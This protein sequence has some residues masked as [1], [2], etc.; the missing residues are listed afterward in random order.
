MSDLEVAIFKAHRECL[1]SSWAGECTR[2]ASLV[3][4]KLSNGFP[5]IDLNEYK[6]GEILFALEDESAF[7]SDRDDEGS[8]SSYTDIYEARSR[9]YHSAIG[10]PLVLIM[11]LTKTGLRPD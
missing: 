4:R 6:L 9:Q 11:L 3:P 2:N 8:D 5:R 7:L 10:N 1:K